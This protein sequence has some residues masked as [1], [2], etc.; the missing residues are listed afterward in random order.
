MTTRTGRTATILLVV[1]A[2]LLATVA[3]TAWARA[4]QCKPD[5]K[6]E[7]TKRADILTGTP[8]PDRIFGYGGGDQLYGLGAGDRLVGGRGNDF[9]AGGD[10]DQAD[11]ILDGGGGQD[12]YSFRDSWGDDVIIDTAIADNDWQTSN[13]LI[14]YSAAGPLTVDLN[15]DSGP[16][17]EVSDGINTVNWD[18]N[19]IDTA[20]IRTDSSDSITGNSVANYLENKDS[21]GGDEIF[22]GGG[23]DIIEN[24]DETGIDTVS[25]EGGNDTIYNADGSSTDTVFG[26]EGN[27]EIE[28]LGYDEDN[29]GDIDNS[30]GNDTV[31]GGEGDD[32]IN[33]QDGFAGDIVDCGENP[34][35]DTTNPDN[36]TV[37]AD[38]GDTVTNCES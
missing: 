15:S 26:G 8:S 22:G 31:L 13:D 2:L 24:G 32:T 11:D 36:D 25:G 5:R 30:G 18:G 6:C 14:F 34:G 12:G 4:I 38:P 37:L 7:G 28:S 1:G 21:S 17:P 10:G 16:L 23:D 9:L 33:V 27:D 20:R 35:G 3:G 29:D 19:V